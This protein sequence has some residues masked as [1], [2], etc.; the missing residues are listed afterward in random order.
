MQFHNNNYIYNLLIFPTLSNQCKLIANH[1]SGHP[2]GILSHLNE[3][4]VLLDDVQQSHGDVILRSAI[5]RLIVIDGLIEMMNNYIIIK[6]I[7]IITNGGINYLKNNN[8]SEGIKKAQQK[9][10]HSNN[11]NNNGVIEKRKNQSIN[12]ASKLTFQLWCR[13]QPR[14]WCRSEERRSSSRSSPEDSQN[15]G[16]WAAEQC[17]VMQSFVIIVIII[18]NIN[19][20]MYL[21]IIYGY[22]LVY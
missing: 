11:S 7:I 14:V 8:W 17:P 10:K 20:M 19:L 15:V 21:S 3:I 16:P 12:Q 18:I 4:V 22:Q 2:A 5:N 1:V 6:S 9:K 13:R